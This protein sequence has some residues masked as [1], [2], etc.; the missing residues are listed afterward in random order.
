MKKIVLFLIGIVFATACGSDKFKNSELPIF[1]EK[2]FDEETNDTVYHSIPEFDLTNQ[3]GKKITRKDVTGK[4][5]VAD[6]FFTSCTSICP[7]MTSQLKRVASTIKKFNDV[8][9]VSHTVDPKIDSVETLHEYAA[10]NGIDTKKWWF[11]TG[12]E[13][14]IHE[15]GGL[16]YMLNVAIDSTAQGGFL[17]SEKFIL[18]DK[19]LHIR[20]IYDGTETNDVNRLINDI[21]I[22]RKSYGEQY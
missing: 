16:G 17:H 1:G 19:K 4:I 14:F 2:Y 18:V 8:I 15:H 20:G 11:L 22:L 7:K 3:D 6:F 5:Y 9:I 10:S 21:T 12:D 13:S